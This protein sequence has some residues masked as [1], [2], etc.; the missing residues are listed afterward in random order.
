MCATAGMQIHRRQWNAIGQMHDTLLVGTQVAFLTTME[1]VGSVLLANNHRCTS[2]H[3][4]AVGQTTPCSEGGPTNLTLVG[5]MNANENTLAIRIF[6]AI[7]II[8]AA[9]VC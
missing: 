9:A 3:D 2:V 8:S 6:I 1:N 4:D 7:G 5:T